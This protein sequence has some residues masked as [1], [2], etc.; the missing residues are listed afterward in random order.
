M[1]ALYHRFLIRW[2]EVAMW[3]AHVGGRVGAMLYHGRK[4]QFHETALLKLKEAR[5]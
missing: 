4:C 5:K 1:R 2:H 3:D